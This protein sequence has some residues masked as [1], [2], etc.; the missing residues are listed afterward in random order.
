MIGIGNSANFQFSDCG[1]PVTETWSNPELRV[2]RVDKSARPVRAGLLE[3]AAKSDLE[4]WSPLDHGREPSPV[5]AATRLS[6][7]LGM[8]WVPATEQKPLALRNEY[9]YR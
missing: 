8:A 5:R 7:R 3:S 4:L 2:V 6:P 1:W 9:L